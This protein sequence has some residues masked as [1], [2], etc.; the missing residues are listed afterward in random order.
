MDV[1]IEKY[2]WN[3]V[4]AR[5]FTDFLLPMLEYNPIIRASAVECLKQA[6][7]KQG[8]SAED[9]ILEIA[10]ERQNSL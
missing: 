8:E 7:I 3:P 2:E 4:V 5:D 10:V 9:D 6:W 1:L